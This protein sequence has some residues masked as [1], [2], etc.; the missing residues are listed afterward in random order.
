MFEAMGNMGPFGKFLLLVGKVP[1]TRRAV[2]SERLIQRGARSRSTHHRP[3]TSARHSRSA[4]QQRQFLEAR[5]DAAV[6]AR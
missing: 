6:A 2:R 1:P 4:P 3:R 5:D